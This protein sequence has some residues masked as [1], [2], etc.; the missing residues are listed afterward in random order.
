MRFDE[1]PYHRVT[2]EEAEAAYQAL[3]Q[4]LQAVSCEADCLAVLK[5][6]D[7][8]TEMLPPIDLCYVRHGMNVNDPFYAGKQ[9][10]YDEIGPR[11]GELQ[12]R[13]YKLMEESPF[14]AFFEKTVGAFAFRLILS[15][16]KGYD[17][18]IIPLQ[19]E[20]NAL[21]SRYN[22][23]VSNARADYRGER[24]SR[25]SLTRD[26]QS[27]DREVRKE[28]YHAAIASWEEQRGELEEIY[29]SLVKNRARQ[30]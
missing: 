30:A 20:E 11:L 18:S 16:L 1:M 15:G 25:S 3:F 6:H 17:S 8:L 21:L 12:N 13:F 2:Y 19:Q 10:Y 23:L 4:S 9:A 26:Q 22:Q 27:A 14:S 24:V 28:A 7:R 29:D 5:E